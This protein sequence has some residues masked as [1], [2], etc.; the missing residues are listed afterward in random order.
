MLY[1]LQ[2]EIIVAI[3]AIVAL[4]GVVMAMSIEIEEAA[5]AFTERLEKCVR[6]RK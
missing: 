3:W 2:G 6:K 5:V 4:Y 1:I